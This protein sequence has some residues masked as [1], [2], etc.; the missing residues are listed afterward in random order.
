M[1]DLSRSLEVCR[2]VE[3]HARLVM[4]WRNDPHTRAMSFHHQPKVWD[5]FWL[6]FRDTYFRHSGLPP[7]FLR[8]DGERVAFVRYQPAAH[9]ESVGGVAVDV[10]LNVSPGAR[11][12]GFGRAA[13]EFGSE[14][15][16]HSTGV[17]CVVAEIR[18][19]NEASL[20]AFAAAGYRLFDETEKIIEDTSER[21]RIARYIH[22]LTPQILAR[23][24]RD[25]PSP[26]GGTRHTA[27]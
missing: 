6:E 1:S 4:A 25:M 21:C 9:P 24:P 16:R 12:N 10:S 26:R 18:V 27:C 19:E 8:V 11:G 3:V 15:L 13:L 22:D 2:P 23:P 5:T 20:R 17:D 14:H 7:L